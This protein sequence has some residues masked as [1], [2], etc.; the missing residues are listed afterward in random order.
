MAENKNRANSQRK[1]KKNVQIAMADFTSMPRISAQM[2]GR[3]L[4]LKFDLTI[5]G[6]LILSLLIEIFKSPSSEKLKSIS[7]IY[8]F[9]KEF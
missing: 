4:P 2:P 3:I 8:I 9:A 1:Q 6:H 5:K 7:T